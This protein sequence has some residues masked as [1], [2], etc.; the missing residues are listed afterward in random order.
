MRK[1]E[2]SKESVKCAFFNWLDMMMP[3]NQQFIALDMGETEEEREETL[4]KFWRKFTD[5]LLSV[6]ETE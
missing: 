1:S 6:E 5:V 4:N 2:F 3:N